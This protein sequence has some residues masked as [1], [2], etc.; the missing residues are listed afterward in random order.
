MKKQFFYSLAIALLLVPQI[1]FAVWWK[2]ST[3]KVFNKPPTAKVQE[4]KQPT[5][6]EKLRSEV[7]ELKKKVAAP[8]SSPTK[9]STVVADK[10]KSTAKPVIPATKPAVSVSVPAPIKPD[11]QQKETEEKYAEYFITS[12][13]FPRRSYDTSKANAEK[14]ISWVK[15][16]VRDTKKDRATIRGSRDSDPGNIAG[17]KAF[18]DKLIEMYDSDIQF[19]DGILSDFSEIIKKVD[20]GLKLL[21]EERL[22]IPR[23]SFT[24]REAADEELKRVDSEHSPKISSIRNEVNAISDKFVKYHDDRIDEYSEIFAYVKGRLGPYASPEVRVRI[25]TE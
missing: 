18:E 13:I 17:M 1:T 8:T 23:L 4:T 5:E 19:Y 3:W 12:L 16:A 9:T 24:T 6:I 11:S 10:S 15:D 2:P 20:T 7:E 21:E 22:R 14:Y 25:L